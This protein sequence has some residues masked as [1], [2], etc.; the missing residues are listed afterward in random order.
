M[1][2]QEPVAKLQNAVIC[3]KD[4]ANEIIDWLNMDWLVDLPDPQMG[5][6]EF[7]ASEGEVRLDLSQLNI[8]ELGACK[9]DGTKVTVHVWGWITEDEEA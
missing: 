5:S 7:K 4:K 1:K 2:G 9:P 3:F 6:A 8:I